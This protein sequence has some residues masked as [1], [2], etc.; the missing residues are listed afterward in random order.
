MLDLHT[1]LCTVYDNRTTARPG[2]VRLTPQ[3][4]KQGFLPADCPYVVGV[5][6]YQPPR[7][8]EDGGED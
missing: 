1:R 6:D 7:M 3:L 2:C 8:W 5:K 4:V